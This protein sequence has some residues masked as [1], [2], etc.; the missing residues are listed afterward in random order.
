M[1]GKGWFKKDYALAP[2]HDAA[3][4][5][6]GGEWRMP[7][8]QELN[9]LSSKCDWKWTTINGVEGYIVRGRGE[10][11]SASIFLPAAGY[12]YGTSLSTA[13]SDG[14]YW[15][16]V[17]GSGSSSSSWGLYFNSGSHYTTN[18]NRD[19]G[20]SVRPVQGFT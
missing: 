2:E 7:T 13:G 18:G 1:K 12:G 3:H 16:S 8:E 5:H 19:Y 15:S 6:W 20:Q 9:D 11:V 10:Y 14:Y 17:P 4:V